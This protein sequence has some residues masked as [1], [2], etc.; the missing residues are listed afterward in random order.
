M[1]QNGISTIIPEYYS[2]VMPL[3]IFQKYLNFNDI[4]ENVLVF[5]GHYEVYY[6]E[7]FYYED[8]YLLGVCW[9]VHV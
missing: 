9:C 8:S 5:P 1:C 6:Y 3:V 7:D 4:Q 2:H